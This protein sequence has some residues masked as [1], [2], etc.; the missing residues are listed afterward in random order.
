MDVGHTSQTFVVVRQLTGTDEGPA[1]GVEHHVLT[2]EAAELDAEVV[3]VG[4]RAGHSSDNTGG[5]DEREVTDG[6][7][8]RAVDA[9]VEEESRMAHDR[10]STT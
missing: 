9:I 8:W 7:Q 2:L 10:H 3:E 6:G 4:D 5:F 1:V